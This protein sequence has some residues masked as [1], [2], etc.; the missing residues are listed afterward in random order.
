MT[1]WKKQAQR[2]AVITSNTVNE[3]GQEVDFIGKGPE[4][5]QETGTGFS[6]AIPPKISDVQLSPYLGY[7]PPKVVCQTRRCTTQRGHIA[8]N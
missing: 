1:P 3:E 7:K 8:M 5:P 6:R 2:P 4:H